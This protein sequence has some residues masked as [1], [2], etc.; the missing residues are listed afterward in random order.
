VSPSRKPKR[1]PA[2]ARLANP[3]VKIGAVAAAIAAVA[4]LVFLFFPGLRPTTHTC[5]EETEGQ[6]RNVSVTGAT[7]ADYLGQ[8]RIDSAGRSAAVLTTRGFIVDYEVATSG[9]RGKTL[10]LRWSLIDAKTGITVDDPSLKNQL[11]LT[12]T[13]DRCTYHVGHPMWV[14]PHSAG[15]YYIELF[16]YDPG[17]IQ[18]DSARSATF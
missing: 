14:R 13:P 1:D 3:I 16:L 17:E 8:A 15:R 4:G 12:I 18:L 9:F 2:L 5:P 10:P 7:Y 11:A 6:I